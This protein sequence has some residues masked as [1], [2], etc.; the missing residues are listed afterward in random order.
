M[1]ATPSCIGTVPVLQS[2][3]L[4]GNIGMGHLRALILSLKECR[5]IK[6]SAACSDIHWSFCSTN[7]NFTRRFK[8]Q[9]VAG[10]M[11]KYLLWHQLSLIQQLNC[12]CNTTAKGAVHKA[13]TTR[14]TSTPTQILPQEDISIVIWENKVANDVSQPVAFTQARNLPN[15]C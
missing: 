11:D 10:H 6:P 2:L 15:S 9:H 8:Y 7:E 12:V 13:I 5:R 4:E 14:Y 1:F 3:R